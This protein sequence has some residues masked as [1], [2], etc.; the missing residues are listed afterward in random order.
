[1]GQ[2]AIEYPLT[3]EAPTLV[4]M[5]LYDRMTFCLPRSSWLG[6]G[7]VWPGFIFVQL[8]D[9]GGFRLLDPLFFSGVSRSYTVTVPLLRLRSA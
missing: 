3:M 7:L 1:M 9:P 2:L 5:R 6:N 8:H 4:L